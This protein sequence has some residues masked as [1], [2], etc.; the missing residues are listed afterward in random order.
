MNSAA[1]IIPVASSLIAAVAA[2]TAAL[3]AYRAQSAG[4]NLTGELKIADLRAGWL[5]EFRNAMSELIA[6]LVVASHRANTVPVGMIEIE[7][8]AAKVKLLLKT[9]EEKYVYI[10]NAID[11]AL[12]SLERGQAADVTPLVTLGQTVL[13][14]GWVGLK[15]DLP[16]LRGTAP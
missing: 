8:A 13:Q 16:R 14:D 4:R 3:L 1:I 5:S 9:E 11:D 12:G 2:L 15:G 6:Q 7:R 10:R